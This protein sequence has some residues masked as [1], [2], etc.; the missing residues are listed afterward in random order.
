MAQDTP[1]AR[2][3]F[4]ASIARQLWQAKHTARP[5]LTL[6]HLAKVTGISTRS[7]SRYLDGERAPLLGDF[8]T[9]AEALG[10]D[11]D[12]VLAQARREAEKP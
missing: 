7:V 2:E 3:R 1:S 8:Y 4:D 9:L 10:L 6:P 11:A 12:E 5:A